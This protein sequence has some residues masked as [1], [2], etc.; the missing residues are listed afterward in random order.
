MHFF[1]FHSVWYFNYLFND[2]EWNTTH[3]NACITH[4]V[5]IRCKYSQC[6]VHFIVILNWEQMCFSDVVGNGKWVLWH[7]WWMNW[8]LIKC[9]LPGKWNKSILLIYVFNAKTIRSNRWIV[10]EN[11]QK[12]K[13]IIYSLLTICYAWIW[14]LR[15]FIN[16]P[17]IFLIIRLISV[18][19]DNHYEHRRSHR[20]K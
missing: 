18:Q 16:D 3:V 17:L 15:K 19:S 4:L 7:T 11:Q 12:W 5:D 9:G 10:I 2:S 13:E 6:N 8:Q 1:Q 20:I 14:I